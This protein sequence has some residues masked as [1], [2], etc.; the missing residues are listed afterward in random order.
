[1]TQI[2]TAQISADVTGEY[3]R[4]KISVIRVPYTSVKLQPYPKQPELIP[5]T[6][7]AF[8]KNPGRGDRFFEDDE[9]YEP[10]IIE[11]T[12]NR[13]VFR[14][15]YESNSRQPTVRIFIRGKFYTVEKAFTFNPSE[16]APGQIFESETGISM[17][18]MPLRQQFIRNMPM[19]IPLESEHTITEGHFLVT[20]SS[21]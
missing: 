15:N 2:P 12:K 8:E 1:M 14:A 11:W 6:P 17:E 13:I 16:L 7:I 10:A 9:Y 5:I 21:G 3:L 18:S 4:L 20:L 19:K